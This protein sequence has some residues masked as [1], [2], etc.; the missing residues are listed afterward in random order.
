MYTGPKQTGLKSVVAGVFGVG[1][2]HLPGHRVEPGEIVSVETVVVLQPAESGGADG[3]TCR[4]GDIATFWS[5]EKQKAPG[6]YQEEVDVVVWVLRVVHAEGGVYVADVMEVI[7]LLEGLIGEMGR[8][9]VAHPQ[10]VSLRLSLTPSQR[11]DGPP[12]ARA[13]AKHRNRVLVSSSMP[14]GPDEVLGCGV[15]LWNGAVA[16]ESLCFYPEMCVGGQVREQRQ[17]PW[18]TQAVIHQRPADTLS[19]VE[20][21][22]VVLLAPVR[23]QDVPIVVNAETP[24]AGQNRPQARTHPDDSD[25]VPAGLQDPDAWDASSLI[26]SFGYRHEPSGETGC[27]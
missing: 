5:W 27:Y 6:P 22:A 12:L 21:N 18:A 26:S 8:A 24:R 3:Q 9:V 15:S 2:A 11:P 14:Y 25:S 13:S 19:W 1:A 16:V 7:E 23:H 4:Y 17:A 20:K 10:P